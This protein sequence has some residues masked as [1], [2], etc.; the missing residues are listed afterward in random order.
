MDAAQ[1]LHPTVNPFSVPV[2]SFP[3]RNMGVIL[4]QR[5]TDFVAGKVSGVPYVVRNQT[6][7]WREYQVRGEQQWFPGFDTFNCTGYAN[8]NSA[9]IQL[10]FLTGQEFNFSDRAMS[11]LAECT[12]QGNW[13]YKPAD[14]GRKIGRI[15]ELDYPNDDGSANWME[16][17]KPLPAN[18][19]S[20]VIR[21]DEA[22]EWVGT[23][24]TSLQY[25][26][27]HA[28]L[29]IVIEYGSTLHN[30]VLV[31]IDEQGYWYFDSYSPFLKVMTQRPT[32]ALKLIVNTVTN[33]KLVKKGSEWGFYLP[34]TS[35]QAMIDKALNLGYILPTTDNGT[36]VDWSKVKPDI[37]IS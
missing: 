23:D 8:N 5:E 4:G 1:L 32:S 6:G 12:P 18:L 29:L 13:L 37:T 7:D 34:T 14:V 27:K 20:K 35:E 30:V 9:E 21:F 19:L 26:L 15:L 22:Y 2:D 17:N 31:H 33:S 28:P 25:H 10:K 3:D 16:Y 36:K 11:V 24:K